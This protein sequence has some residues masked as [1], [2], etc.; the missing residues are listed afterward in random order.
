LDL[1]D[2]VTY[3]LYESIDL[4][5]VIELEHLDSI[6]YIDED[7]VDFY[8]HPYGF[9]YLNLKPYTLENVL[10]GSYFKSES[11]ELD[12]LNSIPS[13]YKSSSLSVNFDSN[14]V[15]DLNL[16]Y[17]GLRLLESKPVLILPVRTNIRVLVT[18]TD[19]LHS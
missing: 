15:N 5:L 11:L 9:D 12:R 18:S 16:N 17:G 3:N 7:I 19:V 14:V 8:H 6:N 2:S 13:N 1:W 10:D 4:A